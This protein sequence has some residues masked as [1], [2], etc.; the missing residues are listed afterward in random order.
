[1]VL[2]D[3]IREKHS[4]DDEQLN[5]IFSDDKNI[6]VTA[7]AGCGK[8]TAMVSKIARE[9]SVGH[10]P[11]NKKVL[12]ITFSVNAAMKIRDSL[13]TLLPDLVDN[14]S[15]YLSKVDIANYHNFAMRILFKHGYCLNSEFINL[16]SFQIVNENSSVLN[17]YLT[18]SDERKLSAVENAVKASDKDGLMAALDD[19]WDV[20]NR[21]LITNHVITYNGILISAIKL[22]RK[23]QVKT[24]YQDYYKMIIID[25]FQD[26]NLLGYLLIKKLI[27]NN[28]S[29]FLGD[30][31]QRIYGF[32]GAVNDIFKMVS[33]TYQAVKFEF[34]NNYRF[35]TNDRMKDLDL[36]IRDYAENYR[37]SELTATILLKRLNS[38][39]EEERFIVE[40]IKKIISNSNDKIAV[41]V[42]A[43]WQGDSIVN[44]LD[45]QGIPY[46]NALYGESD[47]EY[48]KFYSVAIE[49]FHR[50]VQG[51]AIQRDLEKCLNAVKDR[52]RE[53][54]TDSSKKYIFDSMYKLLEIL[55]AESKKWDGNVKD[56]YENI[57]F[58]L[59][60]NGLKHMME[61]IEES[62]VLTTIHSAK[63]LE[64][65][66]VIIPKL[67]A[68]V[69]PP[70]R[71]VCQPCQSEISCDSGFDYCKFQFSESLEKSFK[72]EISI[73]YVAVTRAKKDVYMTVNTGLNRWNHYKQTNCLINLVG[74][75]EKDY[76]WDTVLD[77]R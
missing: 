61:F 50:H 42:R 36:L 19:Y 22:L 26:T 30:D 53:I 15:Q 63:G 71:F 31:I 55:F 21:K 64:W 11:S 1:M 23:K 28:I 54:Y 56:K 38:D 48:N 3:I 4:G 57:D 18:S 44:E 75:R 41:L 70:S 13:K 33:E 27:G 6:I 16:A 67:N 76:D 25:E 45:L 65:E 14:P 10:I 59:G 29:I 69:F 17:S 20:I 68:H 8:T 66:Y 62:V 39:S 32:I 74:I 37:P 9:L 5:F 77:W 60:N 12:T 58:T 7:P 73:F 24:F 43:G 51:K 72:E 40:G 52:E 46:F 49:E 47:I 2:E 34:N 35:K